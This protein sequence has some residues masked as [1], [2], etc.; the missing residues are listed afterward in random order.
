MKVS[1]ICKVVSWYFSACKIFI[2]HRFGR[3]GNQRLVYRR[4]LWKW[5]RLDGSIR[6]LWSFWLGFDWLRVRPCQSISWQWFW[7]S[8]FG[9]QGGWVCGWWCLVRKREKNNQSGRKIPN[10]P[11]VVASP[12]WLKLL[13]NPARPFITPHFAPNNAICCLVFL[14]QNLFDCDSSLAKNLDETSCIPNW[15]TVIVSWLNALCIMNQLFD[16]WTNVFNSFFCLPCKT[17]TLCCNW[18]R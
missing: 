2:Y 3:L 12:I 15:S 17:S 9:H 8:D 16:K 14:Y 10:D 18:I 4:C 13:P 1:L 5:T 7:K 6:I 11:E